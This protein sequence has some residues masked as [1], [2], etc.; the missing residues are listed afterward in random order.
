MLNQLPPAGVASSVVVAE[1]QVVD[2]PVITGSA[3]TVTTTDVVPHVFEYCIV[4]VPGVTPVTV[5]VELPVVTVATPGVRLDHV[6]VGYESDNVIVDDT[7]T[8]LA[9]DIAAGAV[10]TVSVVVAGD[11]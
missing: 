6:P 8:A 7:H 3:F 9:P 2:G 1:A 11:E 5:V 10:F 4:A